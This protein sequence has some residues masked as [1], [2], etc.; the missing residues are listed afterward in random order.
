MKFVLTGK[1]GFAPEVTAVLN[2]IDEAICT[3]NYYDLRH[4]ADIFHSV[5]SDVV[6]DFVSLLDVVE[7]FEQQ[8][9]S[10]NPE[11]NE[12]SIKLYKDLLVSVSRY[13]DCAYEVIVALSDKREKPKPNK[14]LYLW[15]K[16]QK[17]KAEMYISQSFEV[18]LT[19]S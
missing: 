17:Y 14:F 16:E 11:L 4:P 2:S 19:S 9:Q 3:H 13:R 8:T 10:G 15:L 7:P 6:R 12:Q 5:F 1:T 18:R